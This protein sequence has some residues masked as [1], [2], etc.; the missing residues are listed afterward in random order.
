L[1]YLYR[2]ASNYILFHEEIIE[3]EL[4]IEQINPYLDQQIY[5]IPSKLG[6]K[7]LEFDTFDADE[8]HIWHE[9]EEL[10]LTN[11]KP[12]VDLT[13]DEIFERLKKS[14]PFHVSD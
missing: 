11:E 10:K 3:G 5:F 2:D 12:T 8:D 6:L 9:I 7:T 13:A 14:Q 1:S 4:T